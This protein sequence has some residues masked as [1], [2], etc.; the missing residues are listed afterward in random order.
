MSTNESWRALVREEALEPELPICDTHHHL[1][2][3]R[4][5]PSARTYLLPDFLADIGTFPD[6]GGHNIVSTVFLDSNA[7]NRADGPE[8]MKRVGEVEFANGIAAMAASGIYGRTRVAAGIV[9]HA[10]LTLGEKVGAVLDAMVEAAPHRFRGVRHSTTFDEDPRLPKH[11]DAPRAGMLLEAGF[12]AGAAELA[13]RGLVFEAWCWHTQLGELADF[14]RALP[15]LSIVVDHCGGPLGI[16]PF[17]GKRAEVDALWRKGIDELAACPNVV[18]KLGGLNME[19][20]GHHW[21]T[22]P[23]PPTSDELVAACGF[24]LDYAIERFGAERGMFESNYP[25][26][27]LA[28]GY[29]PLWNFFKKVTRAFSADEKAR[30]YHDNAVRIYRLPA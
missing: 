14:A 24:Y 10:D 11:R 28:T 16:G 27:R 4:D 3:L 25:V 17:A 12:R 19:I 5:H 1:W 21:E 22:R 15:D 30:L 9:S 2:G 13:K 7:M 6:T 26:E 18:I 23:K 8:E 29:V 20:A